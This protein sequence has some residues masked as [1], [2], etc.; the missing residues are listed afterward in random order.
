M[1]EKRLRKRRKLKKGYFYFGLLFLGVFLV[2]GIINVF[3]TCYWDGKHPLNVAV[4]GGK[5]VYLIS[6]NPENDE[7]V[8]I[9]IPGNTEVELSRNLGVMKIKNVWQLGFNERLRGNLLSETITKNFKIATYTWTDNYG[10]TLLFGKHQTNLPLGDRIQLFIFSQRVKEFKST[11]L[12]LKNTGLL[13]RAILTDGEEGYRITNK[14]PR[15]ISILASDTRLTSGN[16]KIKILDAGIERGIAESLGRMLESM[17][18]KVNL[19]EIVERQEVDCV[20]FSNKKEA[21]LFLGNTFGCVED[22][23]NQNSNFDVEVLF[24]NKFVKRF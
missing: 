1:R 20:V 15:V 8:K 23:L 5:D 17:G 9:T 2:L 21:R 24:G 18:G 10:T 4:G 7:I 3:R 14:I 13:E 11:E 19:I 22:K 12:D 16:L 6:Y